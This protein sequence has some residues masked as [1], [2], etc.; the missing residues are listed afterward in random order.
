MSCIYFLPL[1]L[2]IALCID[3]TSY[4]PTSLMPGTFQP[5]ELEGGMDSF[6]LIFRATIVTA[7]VKI[8]RKSLMPLCL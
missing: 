8:Q 7:N 4:I 2:P 5:I 1:L 3:G 6:R